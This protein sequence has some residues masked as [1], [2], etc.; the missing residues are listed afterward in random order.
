MEPIEIRSKSLIPN[1][2]T[3]I[4]VGRRNIVG[5]ISKLTL[6]MEAGKPTRVITEQYV[7]DISASLKKAILA[8]KKPAKTLGGHL[9]TG[10]RDSV[11]M[12]KK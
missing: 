10:R 3:V 1:H 4:K 8:E 7:K 2:R 6:V 5:E 12:E 11:V 9:R